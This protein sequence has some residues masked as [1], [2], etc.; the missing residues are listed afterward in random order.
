MVIAVGGMHGNEA[1]GYL[2]IEQLLELLEKE[3]QRNPSFVFSGTFLGIRGNCRA[4]AQHKRF[5]EKDLNRVWHKSHIDTLLNTPNEHLYNEDLE[6]K[7]LL[8]TIKKAIEI[9]QPQKILLL[10]LHT[11]SADG[12]FSIVTD[13]EESIKVAQ[14]L[15]APVILGFLRGLNGTTLHYFTT[16]NIGT[17]TVAVAF[18]AGRHDDPLSVNRCI[19]ALVNALKAMECVKE[20]DIESHH[21]AILRQYAEGLP[22]V[23]ELV[24]GHHINSDDQFVM[25]PGYQNFQQVQR[26]EVVAHD[27]NGEVRIPYDSHILMPLYQKEG[28]DGFFL[29]KVLV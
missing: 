1:A 21:D 23:A 17:P 26:D 27:V 5:V 7:E 10:D 20:T 11:T 15:L 22:N 14:S 12:I 6:A 3:P 9:E 16:A 24:F 13:D 8:E 2:A 29:V 28:N 25:N 4:I 19:A 18:E